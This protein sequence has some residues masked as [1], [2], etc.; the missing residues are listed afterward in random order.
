MYFADSHGFLTDS[1][2][3]AA[4]AIQQ[5]S[6]KEVGVD[7][8][9]ED[10]DYPMFAF[11]RG[12]PLGRRVRYAGVRNLTSAYQ[13]PEAQLPCA[14]VCLRCAGAPTKWAQYR[15]VGGRVSLFDDIAVFS[16]FGDRPNTQN[17]NLSAATSAALSELDRT[18][19]SLHEIEMS[20]LGSLVRF[21]GACVTPGSPPC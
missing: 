2:L 10:F 13:R 16:S 20:D 14:V 6:C 4:A 5:T 19:V 15:Q 11:L 9:L 21:R 1:Y 12:G 7:S 18:R 8:S 3:S 17:L